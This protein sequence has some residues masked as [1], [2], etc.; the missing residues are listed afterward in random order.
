MK[1]SQFMFFSSPQVVTNSLSRLP[2]YSQLVISFAIVFWL[3]PIGH[4][5]ILWITC[6][7]GYF[8]VIPSHRTALAEGPL[9]A[10]SPSTCSRQGQL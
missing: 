4:R 3:E 5:I 7:W 9:E 6:I 2:L 8:G 1:T 10:C